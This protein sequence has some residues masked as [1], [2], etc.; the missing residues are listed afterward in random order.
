MKDHKVFIRIGLLS[1]MFTAWPA[2]AAT[3]PAPSGAPLSLAQAIDM[4]ISASPKRQAAEAQ[5]DQD[6]AKRR[7]ALSGLGPKL[8]G[9]Y[10]AA[11]FDKPVDVAFGPQAFTLRPDELREGSLTLSQPVTGFYGAYEKAG[12]ARTQ[13]DRSAM[14][15]DQAKANAAFA[16]AEAYRRAQQADEFV[17][18]A[19]GSIASTESQAKDGDALAKSG[20]LIRSDLLKIKIAQQDARA[21]LARSVAGQKKARERLLYALGLPHGENPQLD[22]LPNAAN[23]RAYVPPAYQGAVDQASNARLDVKQAS[24][25]VEQAEY[26]SSLAHF[27]FAPDINLFLKWERIYSPPPFGNPDFTRSYG[28]T[29]SWDIWDNGAKVF[30]SQ[31]AAAETLKAQTALTEAK[32]KMHLELEGLLVDFDAAKETLLAAEASV[33]AAEEAYRL[34]KARFGSGLVTTTD[35]LLSENSQTK[36]RGALV[37]AAVEADLMRLGIEQALGEKKPK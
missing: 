14:G 27:R 5:L 3:N 21:Q 33:A 30:V 26:V 24:L 23:I 35:L 32:D 10:T 29:A 9:D 12:I 25:G 13:R 22:P 4:A 17:R 20:R 18:I 8:R 11:R 2:L 31:Q 37:T 6:S 1:L 7:E 28:V 19:Q 16:A 36:A 15:L 34:D